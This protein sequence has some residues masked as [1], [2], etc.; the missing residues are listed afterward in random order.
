MPD[1]I[2]ITR[3]ERGA[4]VSFPFALKDIF[5]DR[6]PSARWNRLDKRWEVGPR[7]VTRLRQ[8]VSEVNASGI[9]EQMSR[10]EE[11]QLAGE[12]LD[13]LRA[14]L[15]ALSREIT[16]TETSVAAIEAATEGMQGTRTLLEEMKPRLEAVRAAREKAQVAQDTER[17]RIEALVSAV[18]SV[19][20]IKGLRREMLRNFIPKAHARAGFDT[21]QSRL[22]DIRDKLREVGIGCSALDLAVG[23]NRN[24]PDRDR[25]DLHM[26]L[27][28]TVLEEK[29]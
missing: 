8:W 7:T 3:L 20:E 2:E 11:A 4:A 5:R 19:E 17:A 18:V 27:D 6:F 24:R 9:L 21:A 25:A 28:F 12:E 14:E 13:K 1:A 29:A 10:A 22:C 26:Q 23:A 16:T 15:G